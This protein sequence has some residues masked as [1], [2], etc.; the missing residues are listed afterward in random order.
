MTSPRP[1]R[2][3]IGEL[4]RRAGVTVPTV[5][6]YLHE[7]LLPRPEKTGRTMAYYDESCVARIRLIKKL[8]REKFL[9]LDVIKRLLARNGVD[10]EEL[11]LGSALLLGRDLLGAPVP[12]SRVEKRAGYPLA[13]IKKLREAGLVAPTEREGER[14]YDATDLEIIRLTKLREERG[15]PLDFSL[16]VTGIYRDA[17]RAAVEADI[18]L[19]V[20]SYLGGVSPAETV[21][22]I[23]EA[24]EPLDR[25]V[26]LLRRKLL[27]STAAAAV[28]EMDRV[29]E[30]LELLN[31]LPLTVRG[32]PEADP[33]DD[34]GRYL[35]GMAT[36]NYR[37]AAAVER[38]VS[39]AA[40]AAALVLAGDHAAALALVNRKIPA[41]GRNPSD[42]VV[43]AFVCVH[44]AASAGGLS[45]P[46]N[47]V[48]RALG[49]LDAT[50]VAPGPDFISALAAYVGAAI[51]L[52]LPEVFG[53]RERGRELMGRTIP[54][55]GRA[56]LGPWPEWA[57]AGVKEAAGRM[58]ERAE[59]FLA[60][61]GPGQSSQPKKRDRR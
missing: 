11:A 37:A 39:P 42:N 24:D 30:M 10:A 56:G 3:R 46:V 14:H 9:P 5:K 35:V 31:F 7:G 59:K 17:M 48:R 45:E 29:P 60:G 52:M 54:A 57:G 26:V 36:G 22:L 33:A 51:M 53:T 50:P 6:H 16:Q 58:A 49:Y 34:L 4:A 18:R 23:T 40:R 32:M 41:P 8:Q 55:L 43:A 25:V 27:R 13:K 2:L 44:A 19:F 20:R 1:K 15:A 21:R 12:E 47:L 61:P 28:A 38:G